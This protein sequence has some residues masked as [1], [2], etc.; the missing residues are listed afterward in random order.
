MAKLSES[1]PSEV[2]GTH[3]LAH[4]IRRFAQTDGD[5]TTAIPALT[6]HRR[7]A[8][9]EPLHCIYNLGVASNLIPPREEGIAEAPG[10]KP[11]R[12]RR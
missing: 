11:Q 9:S 10:W 7:S 5:H 4:A 2:P 6:L 12:S 3:V 1:E 8:P